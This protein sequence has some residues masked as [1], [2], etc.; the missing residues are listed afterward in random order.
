M[1]S[2]LVNAQP[3]E[4]AVGNIVRRVLGLIREIIT[5]QGEEQESEGS[6]STPP[7]RDGQQAIRPKLMPSHLSTF[8]PL[9]QAGFQPQ[10]HEF[11]D[12][13]TATPTSD[14]SGSMRRPPLLTSHTSF[15]PTGA[16][17]VT[18]LFGLFSTNASSL[19]STPPNY[20][21]SPISKPVSFANKIFASASAT[22]AEQANI[23]ADVIEGIREILDELDV[24]D[25]QISA[26]AQETI[27][28]DE[29]ILT[30]TSS[31]T[32]Q[33]FLLAAAKKRKFT[34]MHVEGYPNDSTQTHDVLLYG[35]KKDVS[36]DDSADDG[37]D[38]WKTLTAAGVTVILIPDSAI[39]AIMSRV[40]KVILA[41]HSVLANG[42]LVAA[43]GAETIARA[44][45]DAKVPVVVLTGIYKLSPIYPFDLGEMIEWGDP[46]AVS[47][48]GSVEMGSEGGEVEVL[49]PV[50]DYVPPEFVDLYISNL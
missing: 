4:M 35:A 49:N 29:V 9:K 12:D 43:A 28:A 33:R 32:V 42:G 41:T 5:D 30:Y 37:P 24:V 48:F 11:H 38:R 17:T 21:N 13:G 46:S 40:T 14:A 19:A 27:H 1:G 18:S 26:Y 25:E 39:S 2:R 34:V 23:K 16:P 31:L 15:A 10:T 20:T 44:A 7:S 36:L 45:K 47:N 22:Q 8:S 50:Y 3:R 6:S